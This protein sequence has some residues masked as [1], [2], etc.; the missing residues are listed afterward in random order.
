ME[1]NNNYFA[2]EGLWEPKMQN[3]IYDYLIHSG[4]IEVKDGVLR[5]RHSGPN[6][7]NYGYHPR[8][9][10]TNKS[11]LYDVLGYVDKDAEKWYS[12]WKNENGVA[13]VKDNIQNVDIY[14]GLYD[15]K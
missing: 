15:I 11:T 2:I 5:D 13:V 12:C 4:P 9:G 8:L 14:N 10:H 3:I 6:P 1:Y 7:K